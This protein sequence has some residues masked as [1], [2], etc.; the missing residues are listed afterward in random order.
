MADSSR[1]RRTP[2]AS[3]S[4]TVRPHPGMMPT[5]AWVSANRA[6]SDA[7]R[8]SQ[9]RASSKPPVMATP[10]I[11]PITGLGIFGIG[12]GRRPVAAARRR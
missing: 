12:P 11:A 9:L 7:I 3:A 1:A 5:R 8:K 4:S 6:R 2:T 10:L